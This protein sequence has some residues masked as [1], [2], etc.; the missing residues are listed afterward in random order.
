[1]LLAHCL[2]NSLMQRLLLNEVKDLFKVLHHYNIRLL[3]PL[4][5]NVSLLCTLSVEYA[6]AYIPSP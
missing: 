3:K 5:H 4:H 6:F 1:M 2:N